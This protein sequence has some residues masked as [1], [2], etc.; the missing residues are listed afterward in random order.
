MQC[1]CV[2][3]V[4]LFFPLL[5][6]VWGCLFG[7]LFPVTVTLWRVSGTVCYGTQKYTVYGFGSP[8]CR[9]SCPDPSGPNLFGSESLFFGREDPLLTPP[10][11]H[12]LHQMPPWVLLHLGFWGKH[13]IS[14]GFAHTPPAAPST[15][16]KDTT[17]QAH[18]RS[19]FVMGSSHARPGPGTAGIPRHGGEGRASTPLPSPPRLGQHGTPTA[20]MGVWKEIL[21]PKLFPCMFR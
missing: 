17:S 3:F 12:H 20:G 2:S 21:A 16:R 19:L 18:G 8:V 13:G 14:S 1:S 4:A 6:C 10:S 11:S 7:G 15:R 5:S 9:P